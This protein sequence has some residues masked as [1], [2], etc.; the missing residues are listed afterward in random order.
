LEV[1]SKPRWLKRKVA[2]GAIFQHVQD[3]IKT[4]KLHTVCEE[5]LCPN[6]G[7]CFSR[8][9]ATFLI[10][11]DICTRNCRFCAVNHGKTLPPD[12]MEPKNVAEAVSAMNL[13]YVVITSVTRD[14]LDDGGASVFA[15][16]IK[17]I[18]ELKKNIKIEI[19]TPDFNGSVKSLTKVLAAKPDIFNHNIE[20]V[21]RLYPMVRPQA[22]YRQSLYILSE[23]KKIA[24]DIPTKSGIMLGMGET[25]DE[26]EKTLH[27]V[28][29]AGCSIITLGQYLQPSKEQYPVQRYL[30]P[31][32]FEMWERKGKDIGFKSVAS[33]PFVRSSY[34]AEEYF[35]SNKD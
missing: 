10:L 29:D 34:N 7:E 23:A 19:L 18:R 26:I 17:E 4:G 22:D 15:E 1:L 16:T 27:D 6:L 3:T 30:T 2:S 32:E 28:F 8:G 35:I 20:T 14:D 11:G 21:S 13:H 24:P 31:E 33:G 9:T 25:S 5:A 12:I